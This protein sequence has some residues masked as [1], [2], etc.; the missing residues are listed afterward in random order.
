[1]R[2]DAPTSRRSL[3]KRFC[4]KLLLREIDSVERCRRSDSVSVGHY[5]ESNCRPRN[6]GKYAAV[7]QVNPRPAGRAPQNIAREHPRRT[8]AH[9]ERSSHMVAAANRAYLSERAKK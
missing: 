9:R 1:M 3:A 2:M 4:I 5:N 7:D 6:C 8:C